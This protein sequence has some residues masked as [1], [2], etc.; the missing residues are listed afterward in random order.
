MLLSVA[1]ASSWA[2]RHT[3]LFI[4]LTIAFSVM[5]LLSVEKIREEVRD[6]FNRSVSGT[7]LIVG[8][9]GGE[10]QLILYSI[11]HIGQ[12]SNNMSWTSF[13]LIKK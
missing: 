13:E 2:R 6:S 9:R 3:L 11:F 10:L 5:L 1:L 8:A 12:A 4:V 7:D